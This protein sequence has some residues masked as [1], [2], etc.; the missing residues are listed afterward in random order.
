MLMLSWA[1]IAG[2]GDSSVNAVRSAARETFR[3]KNGTYPRTDEDARLAHTYALRSVLLHA[4]EMAPAVS[5]AQATE[6]MA[7]PPE[8]ATL[9]ARANTTVE[10]AKAEARRLVRVSSGSRSGG[11]A[12]SDAQTRLE[13][14]Y[15]LAR[16]ERG[17]ATPRQQ[18]SEA[19][20]A[21]ALRR[22]S[23]GAVAGVWQ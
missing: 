8:W 3:A 19:R 11:A 10:K 15:R 2:H 20:A 14:E 22:R 9:A 5:L 12:R 16:L 7:D 1:E 18:E 13:Y 4:K 21:G 17:L 6:I 23:K